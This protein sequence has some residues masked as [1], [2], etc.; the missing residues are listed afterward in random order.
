MG[1]KLL[2][3]IIEEDMYVVNVDTMSRMGEGK[4]INSNIDLV[5]VSEGLVDKIEY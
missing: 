2:E 4:Q 1:D 3:D 5:F